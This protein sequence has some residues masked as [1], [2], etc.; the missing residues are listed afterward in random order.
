MKKHDSCVCVCA[1]S[2]LLVAVVHCS[3]GTLPPENVGHM[4]AGCMTQVFVLKHC[5]RA[6]RCPPGMHEEEEGRRMNRWPDTKYVWSD[7][8]VVCLLQGTC[9]GQ[10]AKS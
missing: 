7:V 1:R 6:A 10:G 4:V 3:S 2:L 9:T 8:T 5:F